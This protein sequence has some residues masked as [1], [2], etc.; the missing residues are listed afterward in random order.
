MEEFNEME[1][2][3]SFSGLDA[4]YAVDLL[5]EKERRNF[6]AQRDM[7]SLKREICD[8]KKQLNRSQRK[9]K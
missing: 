3:K 5:I 2:R 4:E 1:A 6:I 7:D 8:L 9:K